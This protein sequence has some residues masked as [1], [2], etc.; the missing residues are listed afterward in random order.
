MSANLLRCVSASCT[1]GRASSECMSGRVHTRPT[2]RK[3]RAE[4]G[5]A[6]RCMRIEPEGSVQSKQRAGSQVTY[7][8]LIACSC[9]NANQVARAVSSS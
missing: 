8:V 2:Q 3:H 4:L 6:D 7:W 1:S 5:K 9:N